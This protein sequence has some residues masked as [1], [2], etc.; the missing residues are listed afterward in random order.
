M[1]QFDTLEQCGTPSTPPTPTRQS[2]VNLVPF[3]AP[4][5]V[6]SRWS[7]VDQKVMENIS[8]RKFDTHFLAKLHRDEEPRNANA[9][10]TTEGLH[11]PAD[12]EIPDS[13]RSYENAR[14]LPQHSDVFQCV[15]DLYLHPLLL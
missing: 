9:K 12:G 1:G 4:R 13:H 7:W 6:L 15:D 14:H 8:S 11:I 10:K 3:G 2:Q 5:D